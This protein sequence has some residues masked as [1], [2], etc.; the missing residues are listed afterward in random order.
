MNTPKAR[1]KNG[2]INLFA[3]YWRSEKNLVSQEDIDCARGADFISGPRD[4]MN[5]PKAWK[6]MEKIKLIEESR[7]GEVLGLSGRY[8]LCQGG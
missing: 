4:Q 3:G 2:K 7:I 5:T 6:K 1:E 8:R